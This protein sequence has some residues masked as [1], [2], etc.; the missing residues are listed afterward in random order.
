MW[1]H[2]TEATGCLG[3]GFISIATPTSGN[4]SALDNLFLASTGPQ[5]L[6]LYIIGKSSKQNATSNR[7]ASCFRW[8]GRRFP[9][10]RDGVAAWHSGREKCPFEAPKTTPG[11][12]R[13]DLIALSFT[14]SS[15]QPSAVNDVVS[16]RTLWRHVARCALPR[17]KVGTYYD[18]LPDCHVLYASSHRMTVNGSGLLPSPSLLSIPSS[19][20]HF[21]TSFGTQGDEG[22]AVT[23]CVCFLTGSGWICKER[24]CKV[25]PYQTDPSTFRTL[26]PLPKPRGSCPGWEIKEPANEMVLPPP[27][28]PDSCRWTK[29]RPHEQV[30]TLTSFLW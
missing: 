11:L 20:L 25:P 12:R 14:A 27:P 17:P 7:D 1:L 18:Q 13:Y 21:S 28:P 2:F 23:C 6:G 19:F 10:N 16:C 5:L 30:F 4:S 24:V 9:V 3:W 26:R 8:S 22:G 15:S 29:R